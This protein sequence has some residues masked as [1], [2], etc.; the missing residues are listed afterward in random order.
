MAKLKKA[1]NRA[2]NGCIPDGIQQLKAR[3]FRLMDGKQWEEWRELFTPDLHA[4]ADG[5]VF[6]DRD[7]FVN[8]VSRLLGPDVVTTHHG[9]MPEVTM[10]G[11]HT[12]EGV[13]ALE[14][15][16]EFPGDPAPGI[17]GAGHYHDKYRYQDGDWRISS[18]VLTRLFVEPLEGGYPEG[19]PWPL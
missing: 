2:E 16:L 14:D 13:W 8:T 1:L 11:W 5:S 15:R 9:H 12:A 4:E 17:H 10:T 18:T 19:G 3:Y 7:A 6:D